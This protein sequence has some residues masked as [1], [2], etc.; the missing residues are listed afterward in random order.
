MSKLKE[1]I[2]AKKHALE[3]LAAEPLCLLAEKSGP[4]WD[5][6]EQLDQILREGAQT[7]LHCNM[8]YAVNTEGKLIS[9]NI[10]NGNLDS[11]WRG[12]DLSDRPYIGDSPSMASL[13]ETPAMASHCIISHVYISRLTTE[14]TLT[15]KQGVIYQGNYLGFIAADFSVDKLPENRV[16]VPASHDWQQYKG[17]PAIRGTLFMQQRALSIMDKV[18]DEVT[19]VIIHMMQDQG[20]FHTK[21]HYS[22]SRVSF[23][24]VDD[25]YDYQIHTVDE[26][27][28]PDVC[29]AYPKRPLYERAQ[30][31]K[32]DI[33][34]VLTLFKSLRNADETIYLRSSSFNVVNGMV[35]LTFSCDGSHY[36]H[37]EEF[38]EKGSDFWFGAG[39]QAQSA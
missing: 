12:L 5:Q 21:I 20:V 6:P 19:D 25:P 8:I 22:S 31:S 32:Q 1:L 27:I 17:D 10:E 30:T 14:P 24:S 36:L 15:L 2:A 29:L 38:M 33:A 9:A 16:S 7:L 13:G 18:M 11:Q 37:F 23:W 39:A 3:D 28:D 4:H 26:L 34:R 35:G